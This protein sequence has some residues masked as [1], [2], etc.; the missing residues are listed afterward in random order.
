MGVRLDKTKNLYLFSLPIGGK[1]FEQ[2]LLDV[3]DLFVRLRTKITFLG[4]FG[5]AE[6]DAKINDL[7]KNGD[8][9]AGTFFYVFLPGLFFGFY[10][11]AFFRE[12]IIWHLAMFS[13]FH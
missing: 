4:V 7:V 11:L 3:F 10:V 13:F 2:I 8:G 12:N 6:D 1:K 9:G 5:T